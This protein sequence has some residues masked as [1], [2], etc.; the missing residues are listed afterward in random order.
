M[1]KQKKRALVVRDL[2]TDEEV[3][4]VDITGSS[5]PRAEKVLRGLLMRVDTDRFYV[6]DT[7]DTAEAG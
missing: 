3:H 7:D 2:D 4:R 1:A 6:D 5:E